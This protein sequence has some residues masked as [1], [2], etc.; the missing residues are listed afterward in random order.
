MGGE[1]KKAP[2]GRIDFLLT[3]A[4]LGGLPTDVDLDVAR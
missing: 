4:A 1:L 2:D 3:I